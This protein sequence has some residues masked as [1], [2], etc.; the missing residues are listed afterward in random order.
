MILLTVFLIAFGIVV[1][2]A[3]VVAML[4]ELRAMLQDIS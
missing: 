4:L 1:L 2:G 3:G